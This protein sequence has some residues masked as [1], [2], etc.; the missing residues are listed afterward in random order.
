MRGEIVFLWLFAVVGYAA[1]SSAEKAHTGVRP[2]V[3]CSPHSP[4]K[5]VPLHP[6]R[7]KICFVKSH[8]NGTDDAPYVL[9]AIQDCNNG[10]HVVFEEGITYTIGTA[11]NLT[12]LQH[13]DLDI[14][15]N[16]IFT[17]DTDYWQANSFKF[18]FQNATSFWIFGGEDVAI[19]G[20]G[21][22]NGNGQVWYDLYAE[23]IYILR[24]VLMGVLGLHDST[25]SNLNLR[26]SPQYYHFVANSTNVVFD[27]VSIAGGSVSK[28]IAKNTDGWDTYRSSDI[29]I[30]NSV[31][32]NGD[33][34]WT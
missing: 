22:I 34:V 26:F 33:G 13:I 21:F 2:V 19:Y 6:P 31:V 4:R 5:P 24:P 30:Q 11:L 27:N 25:I 3:E 7:T 8:E 14:R 28:N 17:N 1:G 23:N 20:G 9:S 15:G 29:T 32:N 10:G 16:I 18:I 12:F